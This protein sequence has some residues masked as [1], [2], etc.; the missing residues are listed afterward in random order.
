SADPETHG[1]AFELLVTL[2]FHTYSKTVIDLP[3]KDLTGKG[4]DTKGL[5]IVI[6]RVIKQ[7]ETLTDEPL[8]PDTLLILRKGH[9][10]L[11][12][13]VY[14][15][16]CDLF[17]IQ[18]SVSSYMDH[19]KKVTNLNDDY[20]GSTVL[21]HY[22]NLCQKSSGIPQF[23][24][25]A[26]EGLDSLDQKMPAGLGG[27][28][29]RVNAYQTTVYLAVI[30]RIVVKNF[31][32]TDQSIAL[33]Y[34]SELLTSHYLG[35]K[36][37]QALQTTH[38]IFLKNRLTDFWASW[39]QQLSVNRAQ[40][41]LEASSSTIA[42][43]TAVLAQEESLVESAKSFGAL[44]TENAS[45]TASL[46]ESR[47]SSAETVSIDNAA[48]D[49]EKQCLG[50]NKQPFLEINR[51][52]RQAIESEAVRKTKSRK[53]TPNGDTKATIHKTHTESRKRR[54]Q[55]LDKKL[56]WRLRSGRAVETVLHEASLQSAA[57]TRYHYQ[58]PTMTCSTHW[59]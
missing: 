20:N 3:N 39:M 6:T 28:M 11:D 29:T 10:V 40:R 27:R 52:K 15:E 37:H 25:I 16:N 12:L 32:L 22:M 36:R 51:P 43:K 30:H 58:K 33:A 50:A 55:L 48:T 49:V 31:V 1:Q 14:S 2:H 38:N 42:K 26:S 46:I 35:A 23:S 45:A 41:E 17:L 34:Y 19:D 18:I 47:T 5:T 4:R 7:S 44:N 56:F 24:K 57:T 8:S 13:V 54:Y 53:K 9:R 59:R 21:E